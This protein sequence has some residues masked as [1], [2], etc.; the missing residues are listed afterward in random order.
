MPATGRA[1]RMQAVDVCP[2]PGAWWVAAYALKEGTKR[3]SP[4][5]ALAPHKERAGRQVVRRFYFS[6]VAV[7][8]VATT[9]A[10]RTG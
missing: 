8:G 3:T 7:G 4:G 9:G 2:H 5:I 6:A 10:V 1:W